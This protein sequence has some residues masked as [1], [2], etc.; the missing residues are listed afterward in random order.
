MLPILM[1]D[2]VTATQ[3]HSRDHV[4]TLLISAPDRPGLVAGV[5]GAL[6]EHDAN[7]LE[8]DQ[9]DDQ[10]TG[11]FFQR[12]RF[13]IAAGGVPRLRAAMEDLGARLGLDWSM[14]DQGDLRKVAILVSREE[15]CLYDLLVRHR[16]GELRCDI[17]LIIS[18]HEILAPVAAQ[19]GVPFHLVPVTEG[20]IAR[21]E[22]I[23][24]RLLTAA[25]I[26]LVVLA[27]YMRILSPAFV[28]RWQGRAIN[29]HHS[30]LPAFVG[31]RP[32]HQAHDR[33]VKLI[34]ATAHY[35]TT[36]LD[37]GPII[38]QDVSRASHRDSVEDLIRRGRDVE[39]TVLARAVRWHLED[40]VLVQGN[41]T[42]V[43]R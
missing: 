16:S 27:R 36:V 26:D 23:E 42:V 43:F 24:Q 25:G 28:D 18:N 38:D 29:I 34:G 13:E 21:A 30:F 37:D 19:F 10:G 31:A 15:H 41:R 40:R 5:A 12:I 33:G 3:A 14:R 8:A 7:I 2:D 17:R 35:V 11:M 20:T 4:L 32:Y 9:H 22:E 6:F 39:R 1:T